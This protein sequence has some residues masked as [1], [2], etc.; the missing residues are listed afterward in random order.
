MSARLTANEQNNLYCQQ[1]QEYI[2]YQHIHANS[3]NALLTFFPSILKF[4]DS[5]CW[6]HIQAFLFV[7][8][9]SAKTGQN[10]WR[11]GGVHLK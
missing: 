3:T 7:F 4:T 6:L 9:M 1:D 11:V 5:C 2:Y 10:I 8:T